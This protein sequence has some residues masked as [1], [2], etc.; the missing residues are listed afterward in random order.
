MT[1]QALEDQFDALGG[2]ERGPGRPKVYRAAD[3]KRVPSVTTIT[4]RFKESIGLLNWAN[5]VGREEG[6]TMR[7]A[8]QGATDVGSLVHRLV[9]ARIHGQRAEKVPAE[10]RDRVLS[11]FSAWE[12]WMTNSRFEIVATE[13]PIVSEEWRYGGTL[14]CV[15][16]DSQGRLALG[17]WKS[18]N[19]VYADYLLQLAAYG[20]L[21]NETQDEK[22][23]GGFHLVRF[24][25]EHGDMEHRFYPALDEPLQMFLLLRQAYALDGIVKKRAK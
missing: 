23:T 11:A 2:P 5:R 22:L 20:A 7:E 16:R 10:F 6:Q 25:K 3:G 17:D 8:R 19:A 1:Q 24:S 15:L 12:Q 14:D 4:S 13:Q 18:S 21:W 9:E